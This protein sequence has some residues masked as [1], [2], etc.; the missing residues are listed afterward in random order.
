M[1]I[2]LFSKILFIFRKR[3]Q[4]GERQEEKHQCVRRP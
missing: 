1:N 2:I 3:E 4:E